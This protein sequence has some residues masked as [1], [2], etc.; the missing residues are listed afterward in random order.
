MAARLPRLLHRPVIF[1]PAP[2]LPLSL[3]HALQPFAEANHLVVDEYRL[4]LVVEVH[5]RESGRQGRRIRGPDLFRTFVADLGTVFLR[6][7]ERASGDIERDVAAPP[8]GDVVERPVR[9]VD[10]FVGARGSLASFA[11]GADGLAGCCGGIPAVFG[12]VAREA[13]H[14]SDRRGRFS[15][16]G[17]GEGRDGAD[18]ENYFH[19]GISIWLERKVFFCSVF[20]AMLTSMGWQG[21]GSYSSV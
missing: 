14:A 18:V 12:H 10:A 19:H 2:S 5:A 21:P 13:S 17:N 3:F 6:S 15:A 8:V 7:V 16:N 1:G 9:G 20:C 4:A 11:G